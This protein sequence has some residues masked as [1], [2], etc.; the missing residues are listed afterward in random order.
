MF[1]RTLLGEQIRQLFDVL[2]LRQLAPQLVQVEPDR[3]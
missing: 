3:K 1:T 2:Q